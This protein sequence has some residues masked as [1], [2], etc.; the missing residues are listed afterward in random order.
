MFDGIPPAAARWKGALRSLSVDLV[1]S[2][3]PLQPQLGNAVSI[4]A[5]AQVLARSSSTLHRPAATLLRR[6]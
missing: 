2:Q 6:G 4:L 3:L 5:E 1:A